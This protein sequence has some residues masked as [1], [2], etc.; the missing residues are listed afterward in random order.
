[1]KLPA[2]LLLFAA[3]PCQAE[4][5]V[6]AYLGAAHTQNSDARIRQASSGTNLLFRDV[7]YRGES[8]QSPQYY[9]ARGGFFPGEH[10]GVE[11]EF[12]HLKAF[13]NLERPVQTSGSF[14]GIS[15]SGR[16]PMSNFVQRFSVSHGLNMLLANLV[17]RKQFLRGSGKRLGRL[18]IS[19]RA[20]VGGTIPHPETEIMGVSD[21]H[22]QWGRV[23][24]HLAGG[25][26]IR[27]WGK[28]Y[29]LA[30]YKYTHTDQHFRVAAGN[31]DALFRSHHAVFGVGLHF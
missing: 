21:E 17:V 27:L 19:G 12:I 2:A 30:E 20:G 4:W 14:G 24:F 16:F 10:F 22:Y 8:F 6:A 18:F 29:A 1:M 5:H 31:A 13:G 26:E 28:L 25:G 23:A 11:A 3:L 7:G 9:G 15:V